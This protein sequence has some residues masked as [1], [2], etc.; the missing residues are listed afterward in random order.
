MSNNK[1]TV[2]EKLKRMEAEFQNA[3]TSE[4][5]RKQELRREIAEDSPDAQ[6]TNGLPTLEPVSNSIMRRLG[7]EGPHFIRVPITRVKLDKAGNEVM[8]WDEEGQENVK[9]YETIY[10]KKKISPFMLRDQAEAA[11][12]LVNIS[13]NL[14]KVALAWSFQKGEGELDTVECARILEASYPKKLPIPGTDMFID[15]PEFTQES[16]EEM[17]TSC[18][19]NMQDEEI[20]E[21]IRT[22]L[23]LAFEE[24]SPEVDDNYIHAHFRFPL[25]MRTLGKILFLNTPM[26]DRFL[27]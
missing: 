17:L 12:A 19:K 18:F 1:E 10:Q 3:D 16:V 21:N 24:F 7:P 13:D 15:R 6:M 4:D 26:R 9:V 11:Q 23:V 25:I 5:E 14:F 22:I 20:I 8:E 27:A 2:E